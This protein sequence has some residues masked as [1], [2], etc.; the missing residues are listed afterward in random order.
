MDVRDRGQQ[1]ERVDA[2][3][4]R[5]AGGAVDQ[6]QTGDGRAVLAQQVERTVRA[7]D[8]RRADERSVRM[9]HLDDD[10]ENGERVGLEPR[11]QRGIDL[12]LRDRF[13]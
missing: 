1:A 3:R 10:R 9:L 6:R 2:A 5:E 4:V 12:V 8:V 13:S 7:I 11:A